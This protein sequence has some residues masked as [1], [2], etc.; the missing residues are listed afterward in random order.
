MPPAEQYYYSRTWTK[1]CEKFMIFSVRMPLT[2]LWLVSRLISL[3]F[4]PLHNNLQLSAELLPPLPVDSRIEL[5]SSVAL[6]LAQW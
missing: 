5:A 1:F 4:W 3:L 2:I 6:G